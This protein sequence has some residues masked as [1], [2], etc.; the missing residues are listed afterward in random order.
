MLYEIFSFEFKSWIRNKN[1]YI[2][3]IILFG[4]GFLLT[5]F[6]GLAIG[7]VFVL[8]SLKTDSATKIDQFLSLLSLVGAVVT[9]MVMGLAV[10]KDYQYNTFAITFT[11]ASSKLNYLLGRFSGALAI[12]LLV[13]MT[14]FLGF[15]AGIYVPWTVDINFGSS[16]ASAYLH[17]YFFKTMP[18]VFYT[19]A[20]FFSLSTLLKNTLFNW[21]VIGVIYGIHTYTKGIYADNEMQVYHRLMA[22]LDPL[23]MLADQIAIKG[24]ST[25]DKNAKLIPVTELMLI[26]RLIWTGIGVLA[27]LITYIKIDLYAKSSRFRFLT[28]MGRPLVDSLS[29]KTVAFSKIQLP[30]VIRS[31]S[32]KAY[33]NLWSR[34]TLLNVKRI[35]LNP[36]F[37]CILVFAFFYINSTTRT[38]GNSWGTNSYPFTHLMVNQFAD[39]IH[40][41]I[42]MTMVWFAGE[43]IW[44]DR[45]Y[46]TSQINDAYP[47]PNRVLFLSNLT[48]ILIIPLFFMGLVV[49]TGIKTQLQ[50]DFPE[51]EIGLYLKDLLVVRYINYLLYGVLTLFTLSVVNNKYLGIFLL[52]TYYLI[53]AWF[54]N[55]VIPHK[56][57]IFGADPG[58]TYSE[59]TGYANTLYPYFIF[60]AY[61]LG[62]AGL[63]GFFV[64]RLWPRG[65]D[66]GFKIKWALLTAKVSKGDRWAL[67]VFG[68]LFL[69]VGCFI[70][71]NIY[72]LGNHSSTSY[73]DQ[74][75]YEKNYKQFESLPIPKIT[76]VY[77]EV[78]LYPKEQDL[79]V[80][81]YYWIKNKSDEPIDQI[82]ANYASKQ[83]MRNFEFDIPSNLELVD[84][85]FGFHV[86]RLER[87]LLPGD[88]TKVNFDFSRISKG[89]YNNS[90]SLISGKPSVN[91]T[92]L[93]N[94]SILPSFGYKDSYELIHNEQR[95]QYDLPPR[96]IDPKPVGDP[97]GQNESWLGQDAD[98]VNFETIV[99]TTKGETA[100]SPGYLQRQWDEGD[101]AYF[102]YKMDAPIQNF[103]SFL[104]GDYTLMREEWNGISLEIYYQERHSYNL[105]R[106]M[107]MMKK[108]IAYYSE[109]FSPYQ[110]RQMRIIEFPRYLG[111]FAQSFPNTVPF[112]EG[113][114]FTSDLRKENETATSSLFGFQAPRRDVPGYVTAH[115]LGHQWWAHQVS[116]GNVEGYNFLSEAMSQYSAL[117]VMEQEY[118]RDEVRNY[119]KNE[120]QTYL[121]GRDSENFGE[122]PLA[123]AR[124]GQSYILYNKGAVALYALRNYLGEDVLNS[125]IK[126]FVSK[127]AFQETPYTN[128]IEFLDEVRTVTPDSLAYI[129]DEWFEDII[130]Y[131]NKVIEATYERTED[132]DYMVEFKVNLKKLRADSKGNETEISLNDL[133]EVSIVNDGNKILYSKK[134]RFTEAESSFKI[135][136]DR[137]PDRIVIDPYYSLIDKDLTDNEFKIERKAK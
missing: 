24:W 35:I 95:A 10:Y 65:T 76:D 50:L 99:S 22:L 97:K 3:A 13:A 118:G 48:S 88:S 71:Y 53:E 20:L 58:T 2:F 135:M 127:T 136:T 61:W 78:D 64:S 106:M 38:F 73:E 60:K 11:S 100:I 129:I 98:F 69:G 107:D 110:Y 89:F 102:H 120:L 57:L 104:S 49:Y 105:E 124:G 6:Y 43:L 1:T 133:I 55:S 36:F 126:S 90:A 117:M 37:L 56:M 31:F 75:N 40:I 111:A 122:K 101:R 109:N 119:V 19:G 47:V 77:L 29:T 33:L 114:G 16:Q 59:F 5:N 79:V 21:L 130:L 7:K 112:S 62:F 92:F 72:F 45:T 91:A 132:F 93:N 54:L 74:A 115:E 116:S 51:H 94:K 12:C 121:R 128:T 66:S 63:L 108:S 123:R 96:S 103:Y 23:G 83:E 125:A 30:A 82:V 39:K 81:G 86:Y 27:L 80:K 41:F 9:S 70:I 137:K 26:N 42:S 14:P 34:L 67:G 113:I 44:R 85:Q 68:S 131:N 28:F 15:I 87:S 25:P 4:L 32:T 134:L 52:I 84:D 46:G 8:A 17:T 18:L